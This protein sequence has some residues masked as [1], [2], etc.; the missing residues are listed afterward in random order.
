MERAPV[1]ALWSAVRRLA[2]AELWLK[3]HRFSD[4]REG[5]LTL[6]L[7]PSGRGDAFSAVASG[8]PLPLGRGL[9]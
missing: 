9:G 2:G 5:P 7:S 8:L 4:R 1:S 6:S 3:F